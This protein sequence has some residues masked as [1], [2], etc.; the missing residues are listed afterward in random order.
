MVGKI[1]SRLKH[2]TLHTILEHFILMINLTM[3]HY[4]NSYSGH[5]SS[6]NLSDA[7]R[8]KLLYFNYMCS[9]WVH[10]Q[11]LNS[12]CFSNKSKWLCAWKVPV[13]CSVFWSYWSEIVINDFLHH[14]L[15]LLYQCS[16]NSVF[17]SNRKLCNC[18]EKLLLLITI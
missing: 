13:H 14:V 4:N 9:N 8:Q 16:Y 3:K 6:L 1:E 2:Y 5:L 11:F 15:H 12:F 10:L 17:F 18:C 7:I